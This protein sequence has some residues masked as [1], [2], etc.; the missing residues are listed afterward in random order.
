MPHLREIRQILAIKDTVALPSPLVVLPPMH[1]WAEQH[2]WV[3]RG[4]LQRG[5]PQ[6][7]RA[8]AAPAD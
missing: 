6:R 7:G 5:G 3:T 2:G 4:L 1:V 8:T